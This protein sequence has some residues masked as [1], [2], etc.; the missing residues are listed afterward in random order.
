MFHII[1]NFSMSFCFSYINYYSILYYILII[2]LLGNVF[3]IQQSKTLPNII[4]SKNHSKYPGFPSL[5]DYSQYSGSGF[6]GPSGTPKKPTSFWKKLKEHFYNYI[7]FYVIGLIGIFFCWYFLFSIDHSAVSYTI[8]DSL[9]TSIIESLNKISKL[10]LNVRAYIIS[11]DQATNEGC[12]I[13]YFRKM[14]HLTTLERRS[15]EIRLHVLL[16]VI[17]IYNDKFNISQDSEKFPIFLQTLVEYCVTHNLP[18]SE[19]DLIIIIE[20]ISK[21]IGYIQY[22]EFRA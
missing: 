8:D 11:I 7:W 12:N 16:E 15:F 3:E 9:I 2:Y 5:Q 4:S 19:E 10:P 20:Q 18:Y 14:I 6:P 17:S 22:K 13:E 1:I 21:F